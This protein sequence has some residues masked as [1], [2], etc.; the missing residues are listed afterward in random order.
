MPQRPAPGSMH[1]LLTTASGHWPLPMSL[2]S[3]EPSPSPKLTDAP[4]SSSCWSHDW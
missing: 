3:L 1:N 4:G 2:V